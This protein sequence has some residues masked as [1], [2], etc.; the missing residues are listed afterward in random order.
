VQESEEAV[1]QIRMRVVLV[2]QE[3]D[4]FRSE[5]AAVE[6]KEIPP[7]QHGPCGAGGGFEFGQ[8]GEIV[9]IRAGKDDSPAREHLNR[10]V[11]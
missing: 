11:E 6:V 7:Q 9:L 8:R 3:A 10:P 5:E 1:E 4:E 2:G